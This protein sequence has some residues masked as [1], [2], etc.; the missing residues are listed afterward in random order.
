MQKLY[1]LIFLLVVGTMLQAI[2]S[3][4]GSFKGFLYGREAA[5]EY[6][7]WVSHLAEKVASQGYNVYA[8]WDRQT[9][10][11]GDFRVPNAID[12]LSWDNVIENFVLHNWTAVDSLLNVYG[13][14]YKLIR[15][16]DTDTDR[17]YYM[18][19][20][21]LNDNY[22]DNGTPDPYDDEI[23][24]FAW[25]WGLYVYNPDGD[26]RTIITIPHP[27]DDFMTPAIGF[28]AFKTWNAQYMMINGAG[29]E[30]AWTNINPYANN[31]SLS[32]PTRTANHPWYPA[33][34][35]FSNKI[36]ENTG[37]R[38]FSAQIHSY[39]T[40]LH[41]GFSSVQISAGYN[42]M[43]PNLPIR[44]LSRFRMD[45]INQADYML[46]PANTIGS[47]R[48]VYIN[49]YYTVQYSVHPF[50]YANGD[51]DITVNNYMD[52]PA[53]SQN[54][55]MNYTLSG[56][57]DYDVYEP[58]FHI[59]LD[60]LPDSY[61]QNDNNYKWFWGW[62]TLTQRW[63]M[64]NLYDNAIQYYSVWINNMN[65]VL[66]NTLALNDNTS[67]LPPT[68]L[69]V[70]NQAYNYITLRWQ[71]ADD[72]DF[73]TYEILYAPT[74]ITETNYT[75][76]S[77][78]ND[79]Y[80]AS[81]HC[82]QIN[83][84]GL[85][86]AVTY[87]FKIRAKDKAGNYSDLSNEVSASTSPVSI[88]NFRG[89]GLD[90]KVNV[91]WNVIN[92]QFNQGFR[93]YKKTGNADFALADSY[94][95]NPALLS[96]SS[97]FQWLDT[98]VDNNLEYTYKLSS[99][100]TNNVEF[101]HN[102]TYTAYPRS[103]Y[104]LYVSKDDNT[105]IDS[106]TF[107]VNP[108][109]STGNDGDYDITK[110]NAPSSNYVFGAFW[111]QYWGSNGTY[112]QQEVMNDFNP[113]TEIKSWAI[114]VKSDQL[115]TPLRFR[116]GDNFGRYSEKLY[117]RDASNGAMTDLEAE[118]YTFT[119]QN[120]NYR[121]F[122]MY[123]GNLQPV[124]SVSNLANRVYQ[125]G[126]V[127]TFYWSTTYSFLVD[128]YDIS[129]Q[130]DTDSILV[131]QNLPNTITSYSYTFP[132]NREM[133][134]AKFIVDAWSV[135]GQIIR[136]TSAYTF[137]IVRQSTFVMPD[138]G[139]LMQAN[140]W[141]SSVFSIPEVFG[142]DA[143]GW[144]MDSNGAWWEIS[145]FS[146]GLGYWIDKNVIFDFN[147]S[148]ALQRDSLS[149]QMRLGWN[150][151]P[152]PHMCSYQIKDIRFRLNGV[153][154]SLAEMLDQRLISRGVYVYRNGQYVLADMIYPLESFVIKYY[155]SANLNAAINFL[156]YYS[157][158][159]IQLPP[160]EWSLKLT[161]QQDNSDMDELIIGSHYM[162]VDS[163]DFN[164][165]LVEPPAKPMS[166]LIRAY[167]KKT[168]SDSSFVDLMLNSEY[169]SALNNSLEEER[170]WNFRIETET[171]DPILLTIDSSNF[172]ETYGAE[173]HI[174]DIQYNIQHGNT[175]T[176][177]PT[178]PGAINGQI[179]V[180]NYYTSNNDITVPD[181]SQL[182]VYPNPFNPEAH[183]SF[184]IAKS[185]NINVDIFNIKGQRVKSLH[186]G[187]AKAGRQ[188]LVWNGKDDNEKQVG[189]GVYFARIQ[190]KT[191]TQT[192]KLMLIK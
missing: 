3:E 2:V 5:C 191:K 38:E 89:I 108:N 65:S 41:T 129:I 126:S 7:N 4:T 12:M 101:F 80:L 85:T 115:N 119:V 96:N 97:N 32:D 49:D 142:A 185:Q 166:N 182:K 153:Y 174:G 10:G 144:T 23:G 58:F 90:R 141:P 79:A 44:D 105:M 107:S 15:F 21:N 155:G 66:S 87:F 118:D 187:I 111:E 28:E 158:T 100:S 47:N 110:A 74:P 77:R 172:P 176:Y 27:C 61:V 180:Q 70:F 122:T 1:L 149:F 93:V 8:P 31:K 132:G 159:E 152:N 150:I 175:L 30:V 24:A 161:A 92:Q 143:T 86:N 133:H 63:E 56:W 160:V 137:G 53:Y 157:G 84:T 130:N 188:D 6:D 73:D 167:L 190:S 18:L 184:N 183:I 136:K 171:T 46:I 128:H 67:P 9:T 181:I 169:K 98:N 57:N 135:D 154:Y 37:K 82:E 120:T 117:L 72:F 116:V 11:F 55:Q 125:G 22:D 26:Q 36:R 163:Y 178:E 71:K 173:I 60:E 94:E 81:P 19:R 103:Y 33:Y 40:S 134:N 17:I 168:H 54:V 114:R 140:V 43:C 139:L 106:L 112:L 148:A 13:F 146:F 20:E 14:P 45:M 186:K 170:V 91:K 99:V 29:R 39:D 50:T 164:F 48:N 59:E 189:T 121:S 16:S 25:G 113:N 104:T 95:T 162:T 75:I 52:L 192:I 34:T 145:P 151:I 68:N 78:A 102:V 88:T 123:W 124:V 165:D 131:A 76:F 35:R 42:K 62:N 156:P 138:P 51:V 64:N 147:T 177:V 109:A 127:Q 179:I 83:V 69:T